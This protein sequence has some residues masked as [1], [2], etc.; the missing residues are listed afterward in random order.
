MPKVV[1]GA[2]RICSII[3]PANVVIV[4]LQLKEMNCSHLPVFAWG[5]YVEISHSAST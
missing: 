1:M 4:D 5:A 3:G 2:M